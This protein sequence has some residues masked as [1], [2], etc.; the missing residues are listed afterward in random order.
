M[1]HV[2]TVGGVPQTKS[3]RWPK[4]LGV[5]AAL[6]V[7]LIGVG[8]ATGAVHV[9]DGPMNAGIA[10]GGDCHNVGL[11]WRGDPGFFRDACD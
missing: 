4:V 3:R 2:P 10:V 9:Y 5:L 11:E 1:E 8:F 6:F 7:A